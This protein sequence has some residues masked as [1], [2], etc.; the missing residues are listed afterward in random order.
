MFTVS[1]ALPVMDIYIGAGGCTYILPSNAKIVPKTWCVLVGN[2]FKMIDVLAL[3]HLVR[4]LQQSSSNLL[5]VWK[6]CRHYM[7]YR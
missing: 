6:M 4:N 5:P 7:A 3:S 2:E 1:I